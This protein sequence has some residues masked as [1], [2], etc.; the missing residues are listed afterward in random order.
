MQYKLENNANSKTQKRKSSN[1][2]AYTILF[3]IIVIIAYLVSLYQG[4]RLPQ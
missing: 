2:T 1:Y 4:L 3:S